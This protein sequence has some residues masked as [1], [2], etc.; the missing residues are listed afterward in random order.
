MILCDMDGVLAMGPRGDTTP[1]EPIYRTFVEYPAELRRIRE[2]GIPLHLITAKV[3]AEARQVLRALGLEGDFASIIGADRLF[4]PTVRSSLRSGRFPRAIRKSAFRSILE[5]PSG[6]PVVMI[7]DNRGNLLEMLAAGAIDY[8]ILVPP[9]H[10]EGER[11]IRG[12]NLELAF[13]VA[14]Q[15]VQLEL[16]SDSLANHG[17]PLLRWRSGYLLQLVELEDPSETSPLPALDSLTT[18]IVLQASGAELVSAVR[19][20]RRLVRGILTRSRSD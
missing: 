17:T 20:G 16:D 7:E 11:V 18:G 19:A 15:L 1:R 10:M 6:R 4:W 8:G 3:E 12:F 13:R 9:F 2:S 5:V 14:R